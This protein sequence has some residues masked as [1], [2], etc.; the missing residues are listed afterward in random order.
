[1]ANTIAADETPI[2]SPAAD[3]NPIAWGQFHLRGGWKSFW[4]TTLGYTAVVGAGMLL[5]ARLSDHRS[6]SLQGL[7]MALTALQAGLLVIFSSTR[8][9]TAVRQDQTTRMIESHRLMPMSPAQAV[10]GYLIGPAIQ[11]LAIGAAN[12]LLGIGLCSVTGT[13][14]V[15]WLTVNAV[16]LLFALFAM[17]LAAFGS[18]AGKP[19]AVAVGWIASFI[20]MLNI[21]TIGSIL[22]AVNV[23]ATPLLNST[24][25]DMK[26]AGADAIEAYAPSTVFQFMIAA[27]CFA[28]ACRRYRRDDRPAL[29]WDLGLALL[30][31]WVATSAFGIA[32]WPEFEP[33]IVRGRQVFASS[34]FL[35]TAITA[36]L[37]ALAPLTGSAWQSADWEGRRAVK[38]PTLR[39]RPLPPPLVAIAAAAI[40]LA[41]AFVAPVR[42]SLDAPQDALVRTGAVLVAFLAAA[43]YVLRVLVRV[44]EKLLS[45]LLVWLMMTNL[46]PILVDYV[47]W[48]LAGAD[49]S[50]PMMGMASAFGAIGALVQIWTASPA[51]TTPGIIFQLVLAAGVAVAYYATRRRWARKTVP[52]PG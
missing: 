40:I 13:P 17:T 26:L 2:T 1:M 49:P 11:P 19:G 8:V 20:A 7:K 43:G 23:L 12:V 27:V 48:W 6:G 3:L 10:L 21:M 41:A 50:E 38:D 14:V 35:G 29:G 16:L 39:R 22:P 45:P 18:F 46:I 9:S 32:F 33:S 5:V 28:G 34:Q 37:L 52:T 25:F 30:A 44:T 4:M 51:V 47:F 31:A 24:V 15:L 42:A 36:M